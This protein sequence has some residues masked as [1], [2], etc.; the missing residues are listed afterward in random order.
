MGKLSRGRTIITVIET[1]NFGSTWE[2]GKEPLKK[3]GMLF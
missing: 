2:E 1:K 3:I